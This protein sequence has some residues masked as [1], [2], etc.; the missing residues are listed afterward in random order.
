MPANQSIYDL[1]LSFKVSFEK[2]LRHIPHQT[3]LSASKKDEGFTNYAA[4]LLRHKHVHSRQIQEIDNGP[5]S[6]G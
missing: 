4:D 3:P 2:S 5:C 6:C 1:V